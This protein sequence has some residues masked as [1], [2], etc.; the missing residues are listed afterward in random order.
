MQSDHLEI[1]ARFGQAVRKRRH[2]LQLSQEDLA[3]R[4]GLHRT[5][6]A[7]VERGKRNISLESINRLIIALEL[8]FSTFFANYLEGE[9]H[10][11][12]F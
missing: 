7:D 9:P 2:E 10:E 8:Q 1:K 11:S 4:A 3:I 5:Y 6:I 12:D